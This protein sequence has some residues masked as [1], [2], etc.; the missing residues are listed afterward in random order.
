MWRPISSPKR[1]SARPEDRGGP[2]RCRSGGP[3]RLTLEAP[4]VVLRLLDVLGRFVGDSL[5]RGRRLP[6]DA[7]ALEILLDVPDDLYELVV[8]HAS[9]SPACLASPG[10]S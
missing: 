10:S 5:G 9:L 6:V 1:S 8:G 4:W 3:D 7:G 2:E